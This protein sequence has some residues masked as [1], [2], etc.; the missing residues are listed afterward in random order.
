SRVPKALHST[1]TIGRPLANTHVYIL[2]RHLRPVPVGVPGE[3]FIGGAGVARGYLHR[4]ELT[5]QK[6]LPDPFD[7]EGAGRLYRTGDWVRWLPSGELE[8]LG[9]LDHQVKIRGFRIEL[10]EI[11]TVLTRHPAVREAVLTAREDHPGDKRLVAYLVGNGEP[12]PPT[13]ELRS[14]L[15]EHLPEYMV[16]SAFVTLESMPRTPNGKVDRKTLPAPE[17]AREDV[18]ASLSAPRTPV[19]ELVAGVWA[20]VLGRGP[21]GIHDNF[22]ELGG[23]SLLATQVVSR[24]QEWLRVD[25]PLRALFEAPTV[26]GLAEVI[27]HLRQGSA[28]VQLPP[29]GPTP[30]EGPLPLSFAQQRLWFLHQW[31]PGSCLYHIP[32]AVRLHGPLDV[33]ALER[34]FQEVVR[35]HEA[36]RTTFANADGQPVQVI[37]P[38]RASPLPVIDLSAVPAAEREEKVQELASLEARRPFDLVGEPLLRTTLL[39]LGAEEHVVLL[40]MHHIISDGWSLGVFLREVTALYGAFAAGQPAPLPDLPVQYA[41]YTLW[42][43]QWLQGEVL[44]KQLSY[45]KEQLANAPPALD[46]PTDYPRPAVQSFHGA[47]QAFTLSSELTD[48][49]RSLSRREG[50]TLYMVLLAAFQA[51]LHRYTGQEDICVGTPI[52]NRGRSETEGLIGF[53]VNTLVLRTDLSGD[54]PFRAF[55]GRVRTAALSAYAHQDLP[56]E[57][58][59][60][61]IQPQRDLSR[62]PLFQV[63]FAFNQ[64]PGQFL[65]LPGLTLDITEVDTGTA[66]FD[67]S[68]SLVEGPNGLSGSFEYSTDLFEKESM[69]R[70]LGHWRTLLEGIV[71]EPGQCLS[72]LPLLTQA[73]Q[74]QVVL[75]WNAT[76]VDYPPPH[77]LPDLIEDQVGRSPEAVALVSEGQHLTYQELNRRAN[78]LAHWLQRQGVGPDVLVGVCLE[79]SLDMVVALLGVLKAGGA[80]VPLDPDYPPQRLAFLLQDAQ[81]PVLL[82]H[83]RLLDQLPPHAA[84]VLCLDRDGP[85]V[86][87][88][89]QDNPGRQLTPEHLAYVIYTSGSTGT[90]K[91][92]MN[93]HRG[94]C[95][96]LLWMQQQYQLTGQDRVLHKTP[97]SFDVSVWE[98]FWPLLGGATLV[99]ARPGGHRDSAYLAELIA[100]ERVSVL[101][102]VPSMLQAFLQEPGLEQLTSLRHVICSGE[103][104]PFELQERFFARM[105]AALHNLYGP[106]EAAVDV[107]FWE[108]V[109]GD[110][111]GLVPIGRPVANTQLYVLDEHQQP[112]PVGVPG[113]LYLGGVQLA[114][115]YLNRPE[116]T[117]ERFISNPLPGTPGPR[118][119]RTGDRAR[120]LADGTVEY[121]GRLDHQVKLRGFRIELGEIEAVLGQHAGVREAV[122]LVREDSPGDP[123]LVAYVVPAGE[124]VSTVELRAFLKEK[125]PEYMV[126]AAFVWLEALPLSGNGKVDRKALPAPEETGSEEEWLAPRSAKEE[127]VAGIWAEVLGRQ[128]VGVRDNFFELGG[129]SLLATQVLS[130]LRQVFGVELPLRGLFENPTVEGVAGSI[131]Q[132]RRTENVSPAP[133]LVRAAPDDRLLLSFAQQRLW[134]L[135]QWEPGSPLYNIPTAMR[136]SGPLN[137]GALEQALQEMVRRH[138]SLRTIFTTRDGQPLQVI[139]PEL[140]LPVQVVDLGSF[141]EAERESEVL[142]LAQEEAR[143]P[144]D[145]EQGPLLRATLLC[146]GAEEHVLLLTLH[147]I[148][149]DG[150]S[151]G[152]L[153]REVAALYEALAAGQAPSL[154]PLPIRYADFAL[155]QRRWLQG[156]VL[157]AQLAYWKEQ[158]AEAPAALNLPT[159]H[160]RPAVQ[161]FQGSCQSLELPAD[162]TRALKSLSRREGCTLYM[163]LLA[164]FQTLLHRYT[165]QEDI[166]VG[167]P[168]AGRTRAETEG[169]VGFFVNTLV[170]RGDLS[171]N[172]S[173]RELLRRVRDTA[174]GAY[175]HQ[176]V[177]FE[178]LVEELQPQRDLSRSPFFQV[179]LVLQN[180]PQAALELAGLKL[181]PWDIDTGT[182]KF[183][184]TLRLVEG[185]DGLRGTL[186][187][188]TD[189]FEKESM[190]RLLGHWR[191]LLEG[192]VAEPGQCLSELPLL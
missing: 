107:S 158:L 176:D 62:S 161:T 53:F 108:C 52:A 188:R 71:A 162:L 57:K 87:G 126:P 192:I 125:L 133:P 13:A 9:R 80:Y 54:P 40:T 44:Q 83:E 18:P 139:Q 50:C 131:E 143:R 167:S 181:S 85:T 15:K 24:L 68:L 174:L 55:L 149:T 186:E 163:V 41:D 105:P 116:L 31:A 49:L 141:P 51:L 29:L 42:Q 60:E 160:P 93:T 159:D 154:P 132:V 34:S 173:F 100:R 20:E 178:K 36:L 183:D 135:D 39:R 7:P 10:G 165:G 127:V 150:W 17:Q 67:L 168:I 101:H 22:F 23:H 26:A 91:G 76:R 35:R 142:R 19:E 28:R 30:R 114:R 38:D 6:F 169:L 2:D 72:E 8:Y 21:A 75:G 155:W 70:L 95:N 123:R 156:E 124:P 78:Q 56:F 102:F 128:R 86:A 172:P 164:A 117:G 137:R 157:E 103:A 84:E 113:E 45:W 46:L 111:R 179:M 12:L 59:V 82:T 177:P 120:W 88:E 182:A 175:A 147:H 48:Q 112:L 69:A 58:L 3:L 77:L 191:T 89:P 140:D 65:E 92:A 25:L 16:P 152:I 130:R 106:T 99:V 171:G 64:D 33:S 61:E 27:E 37:T 81:A 66:K 11:E 73:E 146:L 170:L 110:Q 14:Y 129:H 151:V 134:F 122:V 136:L 32:A 190:A 121:L 104:L 115:G 74:R 166:C 4:P 185:E 97:F 63:L 187:Y 47:R 90:P 43:R 145:L 79:R 144:F 1:P 109:P 138:E 184:L 118:L 153:N 180:A 98:F 119:Y 96:R 5:A 189:L 148:I 94:I